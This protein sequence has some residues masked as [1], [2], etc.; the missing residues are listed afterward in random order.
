V[1]LEQFGIEHTLDR[2]TREWLREHRRLMVAGAPPEDARRRELEQKLAD[3]LGA[4]GDAV[5]AQ[6]SG[7]VPLSDVQRANLERFKQRRAP[8]QG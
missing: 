7:E 6:R 3:R 8:S 2:D 5:V 4:F 1:L